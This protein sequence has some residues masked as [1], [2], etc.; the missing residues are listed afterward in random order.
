LIPTILIV[1]AVTPVMHA[2]DSMQAASYRKLW[3][4]NNGPEMCALDT[5]NKTISSSSLR[6]CLLGCTTDLSCSGFNIKDSHTCDLYNYNPKIT[7]LNS[8]CTF[9]QVTTVYI[10]SVRSELI[11]VQGHPR[12]SILVSIEKSLIVIL[13]V[14]ATVFEIL[15][16]M[17]RNGYKKASEC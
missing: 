15:T 10:S 1:H 17:S 13:V 16:L 9:Y 8:S 7:V 14:S 2:C 12:S 6:D 5:A 3:K 4:A 11:A